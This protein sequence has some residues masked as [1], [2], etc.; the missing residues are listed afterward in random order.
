M[1]SL[2][3]EALVKVSEEIRDITALTIPIQLELILEIKK[4]I[5]DFR[6]SIID[7]V[8]RG[9]QEY[10]EVFQINVQMFPVT[11]VKAKEKG[12]S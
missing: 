9:S 7:V 5:Q 12:E 10:H 6:Q 4:K 2:A 8:N 3:K 1:L 11:R